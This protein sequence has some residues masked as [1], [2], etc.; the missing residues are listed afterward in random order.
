MDTAGW[1]A[2]SFYWRLLHYRRQKRANSTFKIS[3]FTRA[4]VTIFFAIFVA[5]GLVGTS[6]LSFGLLD[7]LGAVWTYFALKKEGKLA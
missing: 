6:L 4:S 5:M 3:I 1:H 2:R 7:L